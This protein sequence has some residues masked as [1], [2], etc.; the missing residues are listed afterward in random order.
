MIILK[1][2]R[3]AIIISSS[4]SI[5]SKIVYFLICSKLFCS[6]YWGKIV[7]V[8]KIFDPGGFVGGSSI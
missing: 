6:D 1:K 2:K 4:Y 7:L 5:L 3:K 8:L